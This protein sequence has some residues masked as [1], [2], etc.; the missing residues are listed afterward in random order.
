MMH[1]NRHRATFN[2][3]SN[4]QMMKEHAAISIKVVK[5]RCFKQYVSRRHGLCVLIG[6]AKGGPSD[7]GP[8]GARH[9]LFDRRH[10]WAVLHAA[11]LPICHLRKPI[12]FIAI[13]T[14]VPPVIAEAPG[15]LQQGLVVE[16]QQ[17][18]VVEH[19]LVGVVHMSD[20]AESV[21]RHPLQLVQ[22]ILQA[23]I[24]LQCNTWFLHCCDVV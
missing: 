1:M 11:A 23:G 22:L 9:I 15:L 8:A 13:S 18:Q 19:E 7:A 21:E 14:H 20:E 6:S 2:A 3:L 17:L 10:A 16:P 4:N 5:A 12:S 24:C